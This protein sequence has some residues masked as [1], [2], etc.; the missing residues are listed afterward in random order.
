MV[1]LRHLGWTFLICSALF[2]GSALA[3]S[4]LTEIRDII[5]TPSGTPFNGT[6]VITWNGYS[7]PNNSVQSPLSMSANIYNGSLSVLLVPTTTA[8][9][10]AFYQVMYNSSDGSLTWSEVWQVPPSP[11]PLTV[12][13]V[14]TSS[15]QSGGGSGTG[16]GSSS[17]SGGTYATLPISISEVTGLSADLSGISTNI[18]NLTT[19]LTTLNGTVT[20]NGNLLSTLNTTVTNLGAT[21]NQLSATVSALQS[22]NVNAA[23]V[24]AEIPSGTL[25]GTNATF[26]LSQAPTPATSLSLYRNGLVQTAGVDYNLSGATITFVTGAIPQTNDVL[27]AYYRVSGSTTNVHFADSEVPGG[28]VNGTNVTFTLVNTPNPGLSLELYKNGVLLQQN[29]DYTLSGSTITFSTAPQTG[30]SLLASY[31]Y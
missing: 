22:G 17:G 13:S 30:D 14:R 31:R 28:S 10:S 23:Y 27:L 4:T 12:A 25:N 2:A 6:V 21:V 1:K 24:D 29:S 26:A 9:S 8:S 15:T 7:G 16:S 3:Q 18:T 11:I 5:D 20:S 19:Q